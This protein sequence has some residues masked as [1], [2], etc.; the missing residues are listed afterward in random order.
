MNFNLFDTV[1]IVYLFP[2]PY[3]LLLVI[4][5]VPHSS[6][7]ARKGMGPSINDTYRAARGGVSLDLFDIDIDIIDIYSPLP[8]HHSSS[9]ARLSSAQKGEYVKGIG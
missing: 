4:G 8:T 6:S 5:R 3:S 7:S 1:L 9:L 2:I